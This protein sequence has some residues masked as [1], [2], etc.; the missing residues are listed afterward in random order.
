MTRTLHHH[1][2]PSI[3]N[4]IWA[5]TF[6]AQN[7]S[8]S[9]RAQAWRIWLRSVRFWAA[10]QHDRRILNAV[11]RESQWASAF[12]AEHPA[13]PRAHVWRVWVQTVRFWVARRRQRQDLADLAEAGDHLLKDI[14]ISRE[15][16]HREAAKRFW[17]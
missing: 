4:T 5:S 14:G 13:A 2:G 15:D 7:S 11:M 9:P 12:P 8:S 1:D 17:V 16:A 6:P 10:R 3:E